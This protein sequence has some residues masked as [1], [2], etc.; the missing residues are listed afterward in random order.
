MGSECLKWL[1]RG[2]TK[3]R[4][5]RKALKFLHSCYLN[6]LCPLQGGEETQQTQDAIVNLLTGM[7]AQGLGNMTMEQRRS[8][9]SANSD[10]T[11]VTLPAAV[12]ERACGSR[13]WGR[14]GGGGAGG[15]TSR[16]CMT[17][18]RE[19]MQMHMYLPR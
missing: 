10:T 5:A 14:R 13:A 8:F 12:Y 11:Q 17:W 15:F 18:T 16:L 2:L 7:D 3:L 1:Q 4:E 19:V 6:G 9:A